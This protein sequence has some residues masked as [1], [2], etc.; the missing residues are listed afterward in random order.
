MFLKCARSTVEAEWSR[1]KPRILRI[2]T[3]III[4]AVECLFHARNSIKGFMYNI[5]SVLK[6]LELKFC[7]RD[8]K[9]GAEKVRA[10]L[11]AAA[12]LKSSRDARTHIAF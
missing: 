3:M 6:P 7:F 9:N 12:E 1:E 8:E 11:K 2:I 5:T 10:P 4:I